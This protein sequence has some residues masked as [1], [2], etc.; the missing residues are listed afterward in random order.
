MYEILGRVNKIRGVRGSLVMGKDG[1]VVASDIA[2]D[3]R[4]ESVAAVA[5]QVLGSLQ[6]ALKRMALGAFSRF[7]VTG[8]KGRIVMLD[9]GAALLIVLLEPDVNMGLVTVELRH[10]R[11]QVKVKTQLPGDRQAKAE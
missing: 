11:D 8:S 4:D 1:I 2:A 7:V 10:A 9:A 6:G 3:V 5:S